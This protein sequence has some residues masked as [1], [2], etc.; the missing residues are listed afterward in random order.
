M[1]NKELDL[2]IFGIVAVILFIGCGFMG[3]FGVYL[4]S[5]VFVLM[6][7]IFAL[8]YFAVKE[9]GSDKFTFALD[10]LVFLAMIPIAYAVISI[11]LV[12]VPL[13]V[14]IAIFY[15]LYV[16]SF[17]YKIVREINLL[18]SKKHSQ[19]ENKKEGSNAF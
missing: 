17:V 11:D 14:M 10:I 12:I 9:E 4:Y 6:S 15:L 3:R 5:A 2:Y 19:Q 8:C 16:S 1:K 7:I 18:I 13:G